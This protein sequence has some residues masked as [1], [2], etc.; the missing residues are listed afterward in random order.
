[1]RV[2]LLW[3]C[4]LCNLMCCTVTY[5]IRGNR[6]E[7]VVT[8]GSIQNCSQHCCHLLTQEGL[9]SPSGRILILHL[10]TL[11]VSLLP[12]LSW[13]EIWIMKQVGLM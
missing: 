10:V 8:S 12:P 6:K 9:V 13:P 2:S 5:F 11:T 7:L 1:M 4:P 3:L